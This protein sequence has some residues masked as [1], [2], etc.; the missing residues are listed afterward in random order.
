MKTHINVESATDK[1]LINQL[2]DF[3]RTERKNIRKK[4]K[5]VK[6]KIIVAAGATIISALLIMFFLT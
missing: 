1:K 5:L 2:S 6:E 3:E 4:K